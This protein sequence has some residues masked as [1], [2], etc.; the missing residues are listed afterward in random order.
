MSRSL[1]I[2]KALS[3]VHPSAKMFVK[4]INALGCLCSLG[5]KDADWRLLRKLE[6]NAEKEMGE[7]FLSSGVPL[8]RIDTTRGVYMPL[9]GYT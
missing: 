7:F 8:P 9:F 5:F 3:L 4:E 1:N 2:N 6:C